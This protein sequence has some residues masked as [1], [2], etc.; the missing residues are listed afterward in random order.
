MRLREDGLGARGELEARAV[1]GQAFAQRS[2]GGH[3]G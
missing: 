3:S 2:R 1:V